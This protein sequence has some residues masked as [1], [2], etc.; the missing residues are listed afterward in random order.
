MTVM[1][2]MM[3]TMMV[4]KIAIKIM[5]RRRRNK[6]INTFSRRVDFVL[7]KVV[8]KNGHIY[9]TYT[10]RMSHFSYMVNFNILK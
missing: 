4:M 9:C 10:S 6:L 1:A 8:V 3:A 2:T 7:I 5:M